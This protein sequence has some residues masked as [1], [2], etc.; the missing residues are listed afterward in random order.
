MTTHTIS[1]QQSALDRFRALAMADPALAQSLSRTE[2]AERFAALAVEAA[3]A[4]GIALGADA[5]RELMRPDPLGLA[6]WTAA[7]MAGSKWPHPYWLPI[8][9]T[10]PGNQLFVDWAHFGP[11]PLT[12]PFFEDSIRRALSRPFNR[13]FRYRMNLDDFLEDAAAAEGLAPTG[14]IFHMSRC[15]STLVSQ[16]LAALPS[17]IAVSEAAPIDAAVQLSRA[18]AEFTADRQVAFLAA[19]MAAYGRPREGHER[20]FYVKLDSWHALA[21]PLFRRTFPKTPW[22][23][24]YREPI[25]VLVSQ[26]NQRGAQMVPEIVPPS[27]YGIESFEGISSNEY[28]AR[29]LANICQ[30][31][32]DNFGDGG[33]LLVDYRELPEAVFTKILPHFGVACGAQERATMCG[34]ARY[35]AKAPGFEF[36]GDSEAKQRR[37][38]GALRSLAERH[39]GDVFRQLEDFRKAQ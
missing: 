24:L 5:V 11:Q 38:T 20:H 4:R 37:A 10:A 30:A 18:G 22:V 21:L 6:R 8:Q 27:L 12:Q 25:E 19:M 7:A 1:A 3:N 2:H 9:V 31:A 28:N 13:L 15:G 26:L 35:D 23:F 32:A 36:A 29:V 17:N 39:F 34:M 33:G 14:F 16:M